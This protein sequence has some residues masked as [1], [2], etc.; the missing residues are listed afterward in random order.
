MHTP[1]ASTARAPSQTIATV[2]AWRAMAARRDFGHAAAL[3]HPDA[4]LHSPLDH[5]IV[6][7]GLQVAGIL[8]MAFGLYSRFFYGEALW[9][10]GGHQVALPFE[11]QMGDHLARGVDLL[12][13]DGQG[14]VTV[15]EIFLRPLA[16]VAYL[17]KQVAQAQPA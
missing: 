15:V 7:G 4:V 11:G 10:P 9:S 14:Q 2:E 8:G 3:L 13:L 5:Q 12:T 1:L 6:P 17:A 16:V